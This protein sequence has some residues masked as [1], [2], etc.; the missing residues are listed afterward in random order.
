M[1][2]FPEVLLIGYWWSCC[3]EYP[4]WSARQCSMGYRITMVCYKAPF[5]LSWN[6]NG[7]SVS[8]QNETQ[9]DWEASVKII[10]RRLL[11]SDGGNLGHRII[12]KPDG[13]S[14]IE[15]W[16]HY[17]GI[18]RAWLHYPAITKAWL[19][20]PDIIKAWLH[21]FGIIKAWLHYPDI[22][23]A[24]LH[25]PDI[26]KAWLH[27]PGIIKAWLHYLGIIKVWLH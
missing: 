17:P 22:I 24:W 3:H 8:K 2:V 16:L 15:P 26:M 18:L 10:A 23:K 14:A 1:T 12:I 5:T 4:P 27:Y 20:Y 21:Y 11:N 7:D 25:Y 6:Q 9:P 19:H 13:Q